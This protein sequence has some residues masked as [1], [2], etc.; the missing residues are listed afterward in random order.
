MNTP[1]SDTPFKILNSQ[2]AALPIVAIDGPAG[3]GKSTAAR[4]LAYKLGFTLIDT[5]ALYRCLALQAMEQNVAL[6]DGPALAKLC[7]ELS[8]QFGTLER[9][10]IEEPE[11]LNWEPSISEIPRLHVYCNGIDVTESIRRPEL[12]MAASNVSKLPEVREALL[13]VQRSFG[14]R[15]GIVMEGRDIGTIIFPQAQIKFFL[16][17]TVESRAKRRWEELQAAGVDRK[18]DQIL[19]ETQNR[20]DQDRNRAVAPLRQAEDAILID[21][22]HQ[23]LG[24]VVSQMFQHVRTYLKE[25]PKVL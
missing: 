16:T 10:Q 21:S 11:S 17:A 8:F 25:G 6:D 18:L 13:D 14:E 5:G 22:T 19:K 23:S 3:A 15:G 24:G 7:R 2:G 9:P 1:G 20:D 4:L 12:G